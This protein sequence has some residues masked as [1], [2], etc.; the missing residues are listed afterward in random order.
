MNV[1]VSSG[2]E[3]VA[4]VWHYIGSPNRPI[5]PITGS[6]PGGHTTS[7]NPTLTSGLPDVCV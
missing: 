3:F 4:S 1:H 2:G 7:I 5:A 6:H